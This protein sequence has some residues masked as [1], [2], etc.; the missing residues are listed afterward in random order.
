MNNRGNW[1]EP[2]D[3]SIGCGY[4]ARI[5]GVGPQT[6]ED[7]FGGPRYASSGGSDARRDRLTK[8]AAPPSDGHTCTPSTKS[9]QPACCTGDL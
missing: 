8:R 6:R 9:G 4:A 5:G 2:E 1:V 7:A 3:A